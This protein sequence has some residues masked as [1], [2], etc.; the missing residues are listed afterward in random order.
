M[1]PADVI[2]RYI[3]AWNDHDPEAMLACFADGGSYEDALT[4]KPL[5][6]QDLR[7]YLEGLWAAFPDL[8]FQATGRHALEDGR[9]LLEWLLCGTNTGPYRGLP[10]TG[11]SARLMGV[12][13]ITLSADRIQSVLGYF[14][15]QVVPRQLGLQVAVMPTSIGPF[16]FGTSTAAGTGRRTVPG[17]F[18][19]TFVTARS[20]QEVQAIKDG[21]KDVIRDLLPAAGFIGWVGMT[22][23]R[24]MMT[25]TAWDRPE[26]VQQ[27]HESPHHR[28]AV[29]RVMSNELVDSGYFSVWVP[30]HISPAWVRCPSCQQM[31]H[32]RG[33]GARCGCGAVL[34]EP[35]PFW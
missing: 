13:L 7:A 5:Q 8:S 26:D 12:D 6:G 19:I 14:D 17:A 35:P 2:D 9:V 24:R 33:E 23:G 20:D 3:G 21:S 16:R 30:H 15:T 32:I 25:V 22:V 34:P 27:V 10:P 31:N 18:S 29:D 11:R 4:A 28:Q 1:D